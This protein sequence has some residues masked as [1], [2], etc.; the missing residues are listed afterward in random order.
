MLGGAVQLLQIGPMTTA[1]VLISSLVAIALVVGVVKMVVGLA[2]APE[3]Y[4]NH[5]GFHYTS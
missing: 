5:S 4:E 1:I 2:S 3:G